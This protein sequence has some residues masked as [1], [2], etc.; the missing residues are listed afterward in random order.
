MTSKSRRSELLIIFTVVFIDLLGF[1]IVMPLLPRYGESF[2]A[3]KWTLGMLMA[4]FSAMQF[5]FAPFWGRISDRVGRRPILILGLAGSTCAYTLFGFATSLGASGTLLG[6]NALT[7]IFVSRI[8][9]GIAGATI[10]TAQAYI[11]D[12]TESNERGKG[13]ALIGMAF[14]IGF[15]F[16]P[17][18][19]AL[20]V[21]SEGT[22]PSAMPG[23]VAAGLS[24]LALLA[25]IFRL[26][27][28][29]NENSK[30]VNRSRFG[31]AE[32][33]QTFST[34]QLSFV[35]GIL[36]LAT[37]TF[38][39]FEVALSLLTKDFGLNLDSNFYLYSFVGF[40][41]ALT[42]GGLVRRLIPKWGEKKMART[43]AILMIVGF[44]GMGL[45][46]KQQSLPLLWAVLPISVVG[47]AAVTPSLHSLMSLEAS[48][49]QQGEV[50]GLGQSV[51]S[52]ARILGPALAPAIYYG[53]A[54]YTMYWIDA[55]LIVLG[56]LMVV[57]LRQNAQS[58]D[59][60]Q[61]SVEAAS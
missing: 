34:P 14:G 8:G 16:G 50:L 33:R 31:M 48:E 47:F 2:S 39:Q 41:L 11:A 18:I 26:R 10:S 21:G 9:A 49:S 40:V 51:S 54:S 17:L 61:A 55:G 22:A 58:S 60:S 32:L 43:G 3:D 7:W 44:V 46:A 19:G 42:Q 38:A 35:L 6:L 23:Y 15:T 27:E 52:I 29:L 57:K 25:A 12:V 36:F 37:F 30:P 5:L 59:E 20:S 1:G 24:G 28:S 56:L 53:L 45:A 13:M 4:S